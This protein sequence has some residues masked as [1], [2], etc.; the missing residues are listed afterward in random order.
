V[1]SYLTSRPSRDVV[2]AGHQ[3]VTR[4]WWQQ[5]QARFDLVASELVLAEASAGDPAAA[6]E[7]LQFL[8]ALELLE[9]TDEAL[10]LAETLLR[11]QAVPRKAAED[12][13]HIAVAVTNGIDYMVTW[14]CRHIAN[15][16]LR[17]HIDAVCR[18]AGYAPTILC[19]PDELMESIDDHD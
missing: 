3:R 18:E 16:V 6:R 7:R 5:A 12:A 19:T 10:A 8:N 4:D 15:A 17:A 9:A 11:A 2:I 14:N 1:I 13:A